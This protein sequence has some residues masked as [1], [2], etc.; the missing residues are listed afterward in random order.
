MPRRSP[1]LRAFA[2]YDAYGNITGMVK[3]AKKKPSGFHWKEITA[4]IC[5][6]TTTTTT[7]S[8]T[9]TTTTTV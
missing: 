5:C 7:T 4:N 8:T 3:M 9:T 1:R 6:T 2:R